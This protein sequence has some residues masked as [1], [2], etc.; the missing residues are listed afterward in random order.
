V[1]VV[2]AAPRA[3]EVPAVESAPPG[4]VPASA[5]ADSPHPHGDELHAD[6]PI[7]LDEP[8]AGE[9]KAE[10][11]SEPTNEAPAADPVAA[12]FEDERPVPDHDTAGGD[13]LPADAPTFAPAD[14]T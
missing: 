3:H 5:V 9:P 10:P 7:D 12:P 8:A 13:E 14:E 11:E 1:P 6:A 4:E 2:D